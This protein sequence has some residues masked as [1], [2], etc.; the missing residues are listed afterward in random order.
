MDGDMWPDLLLSL[1]LAMLSIPIG[2]ADA[3]P[4]RMEL[5]IEVLG[6]DGTTTSR[7]FTLTASQCDSVRS[8]WLQVHG[9]R[10]QTQASVQVNSSV[11]IPLRNDT[12]SVAAPGKAFGGIG[13]GFSTLELTLALPTGSA[14]AG[15]NT[16]RFRFNESDGLA[17]GYRVLAWNFVTDDGSKVL[18]PTDFV[19]D[20]PESWTPPLPDV[21]SINA[22]QEL[23]HTAPLVA[24]SLRNSPRIQAH[25]ADCHAHN[26]LDLK[27]F[28]FSNTSI[29][30]RS[31][32]HGLT[33]LQGEQIASYIRSLPLPSPGR[34]WN[35]PYQPGPG[36]DEQ[37][38]SNWAAGAGLVWVLDRDTDALQYLLLEHRTRLSEAASA[39]SVHDPHELVA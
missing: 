15:G 3:T 25:C 6:S 19:E 8:L 39:R 22:G 2:S 26:G 14:V 27:Y 9:L 24:S 37:P 17:S 36:L 23:W 5:P 11:W 20:A 35:P 10:Y 38:V 7:T 13:G 16:I 34:P 1:F 12:V 4:G 33:T 18:P 32:F 31:R 29:V 30:A 28:N 21:D